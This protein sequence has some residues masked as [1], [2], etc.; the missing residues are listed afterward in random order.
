[1]YSLSFFFLSLFCFYFSYS[2]VSNEDF[3]SALETLQDDVEARISLASLL[4]EEGRENEAISLLSPPKD[5]GTY[6]NVF[7]VIEVLSWRH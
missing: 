1:L 7:F 4:V 5:S 3:V 2:S 6:N